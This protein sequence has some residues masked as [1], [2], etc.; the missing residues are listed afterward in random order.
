MADAPSS[1]ECVVADA[2]HTLAGMLRN[3][4]TP[5]DERDVCTCRVCDVMCETSGV[6]VIAASRDDVVAAIDAA[7]AHVARWR[8]DVVSGV[9]FAS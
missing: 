6:H 7:L 5:R 8:R 2:T 1:F 4:L 3:R 9:A